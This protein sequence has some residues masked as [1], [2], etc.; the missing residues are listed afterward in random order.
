MAVVVCAVLIAGHG[1]DVNGTL[2]NACYW[3]RWNAAAR[4]APTSFN[5]PM[6]YLSTIAWIHKTFPTRQRT[7]ELLRPELD[8]R[9]LSQHD[10]ELATGF[11]PG[12]SMDWHVSVPVLQM[13]QVLPTFILTLSNIAS[14][15]CRN[16]SC[17]VRLWLLPHSTQVEHMEAPSRFRCSLSRRIDIWHLQAIFA[18]LQVRQLLGESPGFHYGIEPCR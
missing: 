15:W 5:R 7:A 13:L 16:L 11:L 2:S 10:Y 12:P 9:V 8:E 6:S 14:V 3:F 4:P 18:P 1:A 17:G